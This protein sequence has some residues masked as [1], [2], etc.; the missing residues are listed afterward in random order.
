MRYRLTFG[1]CAAVTTISVLTAACSAEPPSPSHPTTTYADV[2]IDLSSSTDPSTGAIVFPADRLDLTEEE[3]EVLS[4]ASTIEIAR[5]AQEQGVDWWASTQSGYSTLYSSSTNFGVWTEDQASRFAFSMPSTNA[6]MIANGI[7]EDGSLPV[8]DGSAEQPDLSSNREIAAHN[9]SLDDDALEVVRSC[10]QSEQAERFSPVAVITGPWWSEITAVRT[11]FS[12][13][14]AVT[15]IYDEL[16]GCLED[17]GLTPDPEK[18]GLPVGADDESLDE[19][20]IRLALQVVQCKTSIDFVP[21]LAN[22]VAEQEAPVLVEYAQDM[23]ANRA[24]ADAI[25][26]EARAVVDAAQAANQ[27]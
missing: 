2:G 22:L 4:A 11:D 5:C 13:L 26:A 12:A 21:R 23:V 14:P 3:R 15:A 24:E 1:C 6:D 20:Q 27:P 8:H 25:V 17:A 16:D 18:P 9:S 19:E 10:G 7:V